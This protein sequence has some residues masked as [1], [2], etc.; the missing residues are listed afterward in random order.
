MLYGLMTTGR[1]GPHPPAK[2]GIFGRLLTRDLLWLE[3][4]MRQTGAGA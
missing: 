2:V 1:V 4:V 3:H